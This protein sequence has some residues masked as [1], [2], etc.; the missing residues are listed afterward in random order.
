MGKTRQQGWKHTDQSTN[1]HETS[2]MSLAPIVQAV[3]GAPGSTTKVA[4]G[5]AKH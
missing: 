1:Q 5:Q 3:T 4:F 2:M